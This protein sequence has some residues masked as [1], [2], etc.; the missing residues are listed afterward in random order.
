[1]GRAAPRMLSTLPSRLLRGAQGVIVSHSLVTSGWTCDGITLFWIIAVEQSLRR[2]RADISLL[3]RTNAVL[4]ALNDSNLM[5]DYF[6]KEL[7]WSER[8]MR[9]WVEPDLKPLDKTKN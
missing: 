7:L 2:L 1:M 3:D 4:Q 8:A 9:E 5:F 6:S